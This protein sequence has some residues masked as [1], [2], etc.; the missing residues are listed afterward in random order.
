MRTSRVSLRTV[1]GALL[2]AA[3]V[4]LRVAVAAHLV[5]VALVGAVIVP[6]YAR[7]LLADDDQ[8]EPVTTGQVPR[9][10]ALTAWREP[11][12]LLI[13]VLCTSSRSPRESATIRWA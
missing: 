3:T 9:G 5:A 4:A 2:G 1:A 12:T 13:G 11:R 7:R 6:W 10:D 8:T